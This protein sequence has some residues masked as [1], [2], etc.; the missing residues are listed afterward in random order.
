MVRLSGTNGNRTVGQRVANCWM[1]EVPDLWK[2]SHLSN[3]HRA[4]V[5]VL[6]HIVATP[7]GGR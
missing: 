3:S 2:D 5:Y 1:R 7:P 4:A 6:L